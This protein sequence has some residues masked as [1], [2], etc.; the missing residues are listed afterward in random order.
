MGDNLKG[1]SV[2]L[3]N[4]LTF[5]QFNKYLGSQLAKIVLEGV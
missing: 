4:Y 5:N 1:V 2:R 3:Q